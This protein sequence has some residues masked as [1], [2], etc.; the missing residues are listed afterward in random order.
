MRNTDKVGKWL[1]NS[2]PKSDKNSDLTLTEDMTQTQTLTLKSQ[3]RARCSKQ[4]F[5][6]QSKG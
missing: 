6:A 3:A 2:T 4:G 5:V 1:S